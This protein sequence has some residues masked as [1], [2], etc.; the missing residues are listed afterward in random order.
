MTVQQTALQIS[1][2][3]MLARITGLFITRKKSRVW[4]RHVKTKHKE[5]TVNMS[6]LLIPMTGL[7][8]ICTK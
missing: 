4:L 6:D 1:A 2:K 5:F 8:L 3:N 7:S